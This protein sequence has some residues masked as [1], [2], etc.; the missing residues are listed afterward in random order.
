MQQCLVQ[1]SDHWTWFHIT[2]G[3]DEWEYFKRKDIG[4]ILM[5]AI[6]KF[7]SGFYRSM[8]KCALLVFEGFQP[9]CIGFLVWPSLQCIIL[10]WHINHCAYVYKCFLSRKNKGMTLF[11]VQLPPIFIHTIA[12]LL[13]VYKLQQSS[14]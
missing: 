9:V 6:W 13:P 12:V 3:K 7:E 14:D 2:K 11:C 4:S 8:S 10:N 1:F 5:L